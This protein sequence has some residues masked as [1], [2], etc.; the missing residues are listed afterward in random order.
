[1]PV[2][3]GNYKVSVQGHETPGAD[4][5]GSSARRRV[6]QKDGAAPGRLSVT[7]RKDNNLGS[8]SAA[9]SGGATLGAT[10]ATFAGRLLAQGRAWRAQCNPSPIRPGHPARVR[11]RVRRNPIQI[12]FEPAACVAAPDSFDSYR[13]DGF[14]CASVCD[15]GN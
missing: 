1:M 2:P 6:C 13:Q 10:P 7:P 14:V 9:P 5:Q 12:E 11:V 15:I 3:G 8:K 4:T